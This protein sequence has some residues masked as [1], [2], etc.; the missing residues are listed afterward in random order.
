MK[1]LCL[2]LVLLLV[3]SIGAFSLHAAENTLTEK[4]AVAKVVNAYPGKV[5][6]TASIKQQGKQFYKVRVLLPDGRI[7][8]VLVN[9]KTG[10]M[11]KQ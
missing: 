4:E 5:L 11:Q 6:K 9:A 1:R 3:I 7:I 8:N 10:R 2:Q